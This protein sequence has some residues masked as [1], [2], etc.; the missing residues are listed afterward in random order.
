MTSFL[1]RFLLV[2]AVLLMTGAAIA[3]RGV[4]H[5]PEDVAPFWDKYYPAKVLDD[6]GEMDKQVRL[7]PDLAERALELLIDDVCIKDDYELHDELRTLAWSMDRVQG[8]TRFIERVRFVLDLELLDRR[9][10]RQAVGEFIEGLNLFNAAAEERSEGAWKAALAQF[11]TSRRNFERLGDAEW[12]ILNLRQMCDIEVQLR[13]PW[14]RGQLLKAI[15]VQAEKLAYK[16]IQGDWAEY[17][18]AKL[19]ELGI[20]PDGEKPAPGTIGADALG[21]A[22]GGDAEPTGGRGLTSFAPDSKEQAFPLTL[23]APKKGIGTVSVPTFN[24]IDQ[25]FLWPYTYVTENGP[26]DFDSGRPLKFQPFGAALT[27]TRDGT[28]FGI[29]SNGDGES[30]V[31]FSPSTNPQRIDVPSPDGEETFPLLVCVPGDR[32]QMFGME[33]NYSPQPTG[34]RIRFGLACSMTA[35]VLGSTW[36]VYDSNLTGRYGDPMEFWDDL[37]GNYE[38]DDPTYFY[39]HDSVLIGRSKKAVPWSSI[40][41]VGKDFYRAQISPDGK[42]L[43]LRQM[44]LQTGFVKVDMDSAVAPSYL[45]VREVGKLE[46]AFFD[47]MP[48]KRGGVVELPVGTYQFDTGRIAKG[49][50]T[51]M[52]QVRMIRGH[53]QPFEVKPGET[54]VLELGAPYKLRPLVST[55]GKEVVVPGHGIRVYGRGGEEYRYFFDDTPQ[56]T[57]EVRTVSGKK[58]GKPSTMKLADISAWQTGPAYTVWFP[59]D[60]RVENKSGEPV[61]VRMTMKSHPL[62]GGPFESDWTR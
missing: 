33:L 11:E 17:E 39:D 40:L 29:D 22:G 5:M 12:T 19:R 31:L 43:K 50:K 10:R 3:Q 34:A 4:E 32:E 23:D 52:K 41:P 58:L 51:S 16:E 24:P 44:N 25:F 60:V 56:P 2:S 15:V 54:Y 61:E 35:K 27:V 47:V 21:D 8:L 55:E 38:E 26:S 59:L 13:R 57:V 20:D 49:K 18:L 28:E 9:L 62:L 30:D 14:E 48:A 42:E 46:G 1:N 53:A 6:E 37:L 7:N 36:N 45:V